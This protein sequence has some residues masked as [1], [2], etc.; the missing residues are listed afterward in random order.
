MSSLFPE[1]SVK[2]GS[3]PAANSDA[4]GSGVVSGDGKCES[5]EAG[6]GHRFRVGANFEQRRDDVGM[7]FGGRPHERGLAAARFGDI[8]VGAMEHQLPHGFEVSG[9][10][11]NHE[12][13][14]AIPPCRARVCASLQQSLNDEIVAVGRRKRE[15]RF[16]VLVDNVDLRAGAE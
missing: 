16:A 10:G 11:G 8:H 3:S 7:A 9:A 4:Q 1:G 14:L 6:L 12:R 15:R 2:F 13:R 5:I